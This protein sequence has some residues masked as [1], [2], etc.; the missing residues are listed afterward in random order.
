MAYDNN[1]L[2]RLQ[3]S[4]GDVA[5]IDKVDSMALSTTGGV[6]LVNISGEPAWN[7]PAGS[8]AS[9][10]IPAHTIL[11][12]GAGTGVTIA[13]RYRFNN[14]G[15]SN[16]DEIVKVLDGVLDWEKN[17][18][19]TV[20]FRTNST[21][22]GKNVNEGAGVGSVKTLVCKVVIGASPTTD[23]N[24]VWVGG[25]SRSG[26]TPNYVSVGA[27]NLGASLT[28]SS[29]L[30]QALGT[31]DIDILDLIV[32]SDEKTNAECAQLADNL[33]TVLPASNE[34]VVTPI[35]F[36]GTIPNQSFT[37]GQIVN[38]DLSGYFTGSET[39]F[40]YA[41]TA[42]S[43]TGT[44]LTLSSA[45]V[46]SGTAA[47]ATQGGIVITGTDAGTNTA[48]SNSFSVTVSAEAALTP[49]G[50]VTIGTITVGETTATVPYTY[51]AA[52]Q[53]GFE[54]RLNGG[55]TVADSASPVDLTG[56]T[57]DT[58]YTIEVRAVNAEGAGSWSAVGSFTTNAAAPADPV[59]VFGADT[60]LEF[61]TGVL[62]PN[63]TGLTVDVY[64][65]ETGAL[66]LRVTGHTTGADGVMANIQNA[67]LSAVTE[68][69]VVVLGVDGSEAVFRETSQ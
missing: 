36:E 59:I 43:L 57:A 55:S 45:G 15:A 18:N 66:V 50:T 34:P 68:Y 54:Y 44:G 21:L 39:P 16:T 5:P 51:S 2:F 35:S 26:D 69:R 3:P 9:K 1:I 64:N 60:A 56:L 40:T 65:P 52:D 10:A 13:V 37:N 22:G 58:A 24:N 6:Q 7:F 32:Y 48:A 47:E 63:L 61:N 23:I 67:A 33:R 29:V 4:V 46:L 53:T 41:V 8:N 17:G 49:Q 28:T 38:V 42:G 11:P 12:E 25:M 31:L 30:I 27:Y 62:R 14:M 19:T 20:T